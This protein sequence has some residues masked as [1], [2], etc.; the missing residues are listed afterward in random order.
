MLVGFAVVG[1]GATT[2]C[3]VATV[4]GTV[5]VM[6]PKKGMQLKVGNRVTLK[7]RAKAAATD[8]GF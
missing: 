7:T 5:V 8:Q 4:A 1:Q 3:T 6:D 2:K